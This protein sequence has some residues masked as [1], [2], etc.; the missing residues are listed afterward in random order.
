MRS[1]CTCSSQKKSP[2]YLDSHRLRLGIS[3]PAFPDV[4]LLSIVCWVGACWEGDLSGGGA[5]R[6]CGGQLWGL[7]GIPV[8]STGS[9]PT[10][11]GPVA[12]AHVQGA[13]GD[14]ESLWAT[15]DAVA[16][17]GRNKEPEV[18]ICSWDRFGTA[19]TAFPWALEAEVAVTCHIA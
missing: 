4:S 12:P 13:C 18:H 9:I 15:T 19:K 17:A 8:L 1:F 10:C 16:D 6:L 7:L 3:I 2:P 5:C 14:E 11:S